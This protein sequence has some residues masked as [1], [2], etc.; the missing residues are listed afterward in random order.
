VKEVINVRHMVVENGAMNLVAVNLHEQ[1]VINVLLM[2][3][4]HGVLNLVVHMAQESQVINVRVMEVEYDAMNLDAQKQSLLQAINAYPMEVENGV[5][6]VSLGQIHE[7][8]QINMMAIVLHVLN[9]YFLPI[10]EVK[11]SIFI[12]KRCVY[13]IP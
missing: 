8:V 6:I 5:Q 2:E 13:V 11:L 3:V 1:G 7:A 4:V 9:I 12:Q 10:Q